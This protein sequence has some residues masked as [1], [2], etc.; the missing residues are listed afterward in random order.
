LSEAQLK[1]ARQWLADGV[2]SDRP[3]KLK[4]DAR[5]Y[6]FNRADDE[7]IVTWLAVTYTPADADHILTAFKADLAAG[8]VNAPEAS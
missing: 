3:E 2:S 7:T 5:D 6:W 4:H 1:A 8:L